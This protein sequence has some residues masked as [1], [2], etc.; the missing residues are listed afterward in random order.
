MVDKSGSSLLPN[1]T[2]KSATQAVLK[3]LLDSSEGWNAPLVPQCSGDILLPPYVL[4]SLAECPISRWPITP[5][6]NP[7]HGTA[8]PFMAVT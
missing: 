5:V 2:N 6:A 8:H 1:I 3:M 7:L 4:V